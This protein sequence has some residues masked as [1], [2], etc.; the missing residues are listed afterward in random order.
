M[1][2]LS[3]WFPPSS[4]PEEQ[5]AAQNLR[6]VMTYKELLPQH[7]WFR[8]VLVCAVLPSTVSAG[9]QNQEVAQAI[10]Q[11]LAAAGGLVEGSLPPVSQLFQTVVRRILTDNVENL[12]VCDSH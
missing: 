3:S 4:L 12:R 8:L 9:G 1:Q 5:I 2:G 7:P 11:R 6:A 10:Q